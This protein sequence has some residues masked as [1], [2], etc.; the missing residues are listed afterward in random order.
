MVLFTAIWSQLNPGVVQKPSIT[1]YH[2]F[3]GKRV[4]VKLISWAGAPTFIGTQRTA[5]TI[6]NIPDPIRIEFDAG[7]QA[8]GMGVVM[9]QNAPDA[10]YI[11]PNCFYVDPLF[12]YDY[13]PDATFTDRLVTKGYRIGSKEP[14]IDGVMIGNTITI[15][16]STSSTPRDLVP[17]EVAFS[18]VR[19]QFYYYKA[20]FDIEEI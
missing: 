20:E 9:A 17:D 15:T 10:V 11:Y 3:A 2:G 16:L 12:I 7:F 8:N 19:N 6:A 18:Y 13:D 4:R 14:T 5:L 1:L